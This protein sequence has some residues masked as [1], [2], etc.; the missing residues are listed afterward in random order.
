MNE[1]RNIPSWPGARCDS[2]AWPY[3]SDI[4]VFEARRA[5]GQLARTFGGALNP[6]GL[7]DS[8]VDPA[9]RY[10]RAV[11]LLEAALKVVRQD[12]VAEA[13]TRDV[14][15]EQIGLARG[16]SKQQAWNEF[17]AGLSTARLGRLGDEAFTSAVAVEA[18]NPREIPQDVAARLDGATPADRMNYLACQAVDTLSEIREVL[19]PDGLACEDSLGAL[20]ATGHRIQQL[21]RLVT[22]DYAMWQAVASRSGRPE[23]LDQANYYAPATYLLH[24]MRLLLLAWAR[25][26]GEECEDVEQYRW[27]VVEVGRIYA[28][29]VLILDRVDVGSV[30]PC[31][32][33]GTWNRCDGTCVPRP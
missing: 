17:H 11:D 32:C 2:D 31:Q 30:V 3:S 26:P 27:S 20:K 6:P 14:T 7:G 29:V 8:D 16:T 10:I 5:V 22:A 9:L 15:W 21:G 13:R 4:E 18:A 19:S 12:L 23:H 33:G 1:E 25:V 24:V 28:A